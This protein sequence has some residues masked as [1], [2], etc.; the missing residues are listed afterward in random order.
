M[1]NIIRHFEEEDKDSAWQE[2][3]KE[4]ER[5]PMYKYAD[6]SCQGK[7]ITAYRKG[8]VVAVQEIAR[9]EIQPYLKNGGKGAQLT[10]LG[11]VKW[12]R[13]KEA[14]K[15]GSTVWE[16]KSDEELLQEWD[17]QEKRSLN[18]VVDHEVCWDPDKRGGVGETPLHLLYL[19]DSAEHTET[20]KILLNMYPKLALDIYEADE[21][22][23][24]SCLH[25]AT[26]YGDFESVKLLVS[27][28]AYIN[29]RAT[30]RFFLPEDQKTGQSNET[31][32]Q[33]YAYYGEYPLAFAVCFGYMDIYDYLIDNGADPNLQDSFGNT[34]LHMAVISDQAEMY[35]YM[36]KH[37]KKPARREIRNHANLTP[38]TLASKLGRHKLF[39]EILEIHCIDLWRYSNVACSVYPLTEIDSIQSNGE[40]NLNSALMIVINGEEDE[41]LEMLE[42]GVMRQLLD[43]KW[44]TFA[45]NRFFKRLVLAFVHLILISVSVY[46]RP[47]DNLNSYTKPADAIRFISEII[48]CL[49]CIGYLVLEVIEIGAQGAMAFIKNCGHAPAHTVF[50]I[51]CLLILLC[52]PVRFSG[53]QQVEDILLILAVPGSWFFL[54]FFARTN[55]GT[56]PMIVTMYL[57][58]SKD[59]VRFGIIYCVF[60]M[61]FGL[62]FYFLFRDINQDSFKTLPSTIMT[63]FQMTLGEFKYHDFDLTRYALL[64]KLV[65]AVFMILVP[66]L[67]LNMLIAMMGN[68]YQSVIIK[69]EKEWRKQW[70]KIVV[71]LE[72]GYTR[73][74]LRKFH[75]EY[76]IKLAGPATEDGKEREEIRALVVIKSS[77]KTKARQ[78]KIAVGNWKKLGHE[79]IL[80]L[81]EQKKKGK[82]GPL[83][84]QKVAR[85]SKK[86]GDSDSE[87]ERKF[88]NITAQL[89]WERDID[90]AK[91]QAFMKDTNSVENRN[92]KQAGIG[93][94]GNGTGVHD[95][96]PD[97]HTQI[98]NGNARTIKKYVKRPNGT[99]RTSPKLTKQFST[100][101]ITPLPV[102]DNQD[103]SMNDLIFDVE[104]GRG[105]KTQSQTSRSTISD[106]YGSV[107]S[108]RKSADFVD[109]DLMI[110]KTN[111][112]YVNSVT[113]VK[114][115]NKQDTKHTLE[116]ETS[117]E[118]VGSA[119]SN[120]KYDQWADEIIKSSREPSPNP[121][122]SKSD[123]INGSPGKSG[124]HKSKKKKK[125]KRY[126][127]GKER[128]KEVKS[129]RDRERS[130]SSERKEHKMKGSK[131]PTSDELLLG[132]SDVNE[133][134]L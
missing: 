57:M 66:I 79:I 59:I 117:P 124:K 88:S 121:S 129:S 41:H 134:S 47:A 107:M 48:V 28:G 113:T 65:F 37:H 97:E 33:G 64:T 75:Q 4:I 45:R 76:S 67:L 70:A 119:E 13:S 20:A 40:P 60:M 14:A 2:Q 36:V 50:M 85:K 102:Y 92:S 69:S 54:L 55:S 105:H 61:S 133:S 56:G 89:A 115:G 114:P 52:I 99:P 93:Q 35:K 5:N 39:K 38:L 22:F 71:V 101:R 78:R 8:G 81:K 127:T 12:I 16:T 51:S 3:N 44:K 122:P 90:L 125:E 58:M 27:N 25:L 1:G 19:T 130:K 96:G 86:D 94:M 26:V 95:R 43:D 9:K 132:D 83:K 98:P 10:R 24:E 17:E 29:Q 11:Y 82:S 32:Y 21:Y 42:G 111:D 120:S 80:Q 108:T 109:S 112:K 84:L 72:R 74:Q 126:L 34:A 23:G 7:L 123:V 68:T 103:D 30:G 104:D 49:F 15:S 46:L 62:G 63:L 77:P 106:L 118:R 6:L 128:D 100:N 31:N 91:G 116:V 73:K 53:H 110:V 87:D 18:K 131:T